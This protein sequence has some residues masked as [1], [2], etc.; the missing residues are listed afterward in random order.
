MTDLVHLTD[1]VLAAGELVQHLL[2]SDRLACSVCGERPAYCT[3][4][5]YGQIAFCAHCDGEESEADLAA[6]F[7]EFPRS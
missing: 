2:D 1:A 5:A 7:G 4:G 6:N 3:R